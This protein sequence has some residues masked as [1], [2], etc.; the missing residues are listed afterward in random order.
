M[1]TTSAPVG[2]PFASQDAALRL[3]RGYTDEICGHRSPITP[4]RTPCQRPPGH[5]PEYGHRDSTRAE[6][7]RVWQDHGRS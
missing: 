7:R 3:A 2:V 1:C 4:D 5:D 6:V